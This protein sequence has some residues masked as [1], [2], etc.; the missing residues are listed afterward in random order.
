VPDNP[1][2]AVVI[3]AGGSGTRL[4]AGKPKAFV[5]TGGKTLLEHALDC[6]SG[7]QEITRFVIAVP[8]AMKQEAQAIANSRS[9]PPVIIVEGG[10]ERQDSVSAAISHCGESRLI[11]VHDA[12]RPLVG[13][14]DI[15]A[16]IREAGR[17][18]AAILV[19][20]VAY[21]LKSSQDS[22]FTGGTIDRDKV[23]IAHTPQVFSSELLVRAYAEAG[24]SNFRATDDAA[25]VEA[26]GVKVKAVECSMGNLKI[27]TSEDLE[28]FNWKK[29]FTMN[30]NVPV[31]IGYG[32]DTH[33]L[34]TSRKLIIGGVEIPFEKGLQGHSDA[35][36]LIHAI[37]DALVGAL[38]LGDIG[39]HFPDTDK[40]WKNA[41]SR[42]LLRRVYSIV[43]REGYRV[44]NVDA[45]VVA[46][47]PR[48]RELIDQMRSNIASD[49]NTTT[50]NISVKATTSERI[51]FVGREE[52]MSASAVA[53]LV[54][55]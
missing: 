26:I 45:T 36:V 52:G 34:E 48:L 28:Y 49:L 18:G 11:A 31:K 53:L 33:R 35:D 3:P 44:G 50:G 55:S 9:G 6:F 16:V 27:T 38:A 24:K 40:A 46:Q 25:L 41:D 43:E 30:M 32:Y 20:R 14:E 2:T 47:R 4:G 29:G 7:L 21:T 54:K 23:R 8:A 12:A 19:S 1:S 13:R 22:S 5:R 17:H 51:G 37:I 39:S 42:E 10:A 15:R